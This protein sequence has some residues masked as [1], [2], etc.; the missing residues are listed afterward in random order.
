MVKECRATSWINALDLLYADSLRPDIGRYRSH[1][2]YRG[3]SDSSY[4]LKT[5]L[6]RLGGNYATLERHLLRNF[7]RYARGPFETEPFSV[8]KWL[9]V[10][11]HH[12]LPT[13]LLD[14][15]YSTLIALHFVT[16]SVDQLNK[17]GI[18]WCVDSKVAHRTIPS[19]LVNAQA[20]EGGDLFTVQV[21]AQVCKSLEDFDAMAS[22]P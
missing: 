17:D 20:L 21:L 4:Q 2:A 13:R 8:W 9:T 6:M 14:W 16:A 11:Q 19:S 3:L 10:G 7:R 12:G 15:T 22:E 18:V 5:S 1:Y